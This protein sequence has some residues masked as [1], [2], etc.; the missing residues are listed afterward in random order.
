[1]CSH[2]V[3]TGVTT[4]ILQELTGSLVIS[5]F[6][7]REVTTILIFKFC[8]FFLFFLCHLNGIIFFCVWLLLLII[9]I[10]VRFFH[11]T[12]NCN[13]LVLI[14]VYQYEYTIIYL[15]ILWLMDIRGGFQVLIITNNTIMKIFEG[16]SYIPVHAF[17]LGI[18]LGGEMLGH[19]IYTFSR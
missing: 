8:L 11:V 17:W 13:Q 15:S 6:A 4:R 9:F 16:I 7:C 18:F 14:S 2:K 5:I 3:N 10:F 1:M 19:R 12:G